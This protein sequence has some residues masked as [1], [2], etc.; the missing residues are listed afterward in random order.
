[1]QALGDPEIQD[2]FNF[3]KY[4]K[5]PS[6]MGIPDNILAMIYENLDGSAQICLALSCKDMARASLRLNDEQ[7]ILYSHG[8]KLRLF[9]RLKPWMTAKYKQ[10]VK[11]V[12]FLPREPRVWQ[13]AWMNQSH[14]SLYQAYG[15]SRSDF[16]FED[17]ECPE[18]RGTWK[19]E[20]LQ[21]SQ[22]S[23]LDTIWGEKW[24]F[25]DLQQNEYGA[26]RE[27]IETIPLA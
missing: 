16:Y 25:E 27:A 4:N 14:T 5:K 10:C 23:F 18:C 22:L 2:T 24:K 21:S 26:E 19:S 13:I 3:D 12:K 8:E 11:C 7:G 17:G 9:G 6:L 15:K 1:M 20:D